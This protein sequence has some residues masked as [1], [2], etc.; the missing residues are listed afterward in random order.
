M[1]TLFEANDERT[2]LV[3]TV[4]ELEQA[5]RNVLSELLAEKAEADNDEKI[6]RSEAC[7]RLGKEVTTLKRWEKSG[8]VHPIKIGRTV[9]Y[10]E[11]EIKAIGE[12]RR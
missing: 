6:S 4:P 8:K 12:G 3:T 1:K 10:M 2:L 5:F 7:K 9:F 11:R